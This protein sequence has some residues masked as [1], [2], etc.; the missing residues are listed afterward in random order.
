MCLATF[1][2]TLLSSTIRQLR[3]SSPSFSPQSAPTQ[4]V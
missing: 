3:I 4:T 1:R 2:I